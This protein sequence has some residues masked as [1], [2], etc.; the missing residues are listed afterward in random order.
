MKVLFGVALETE[1]GRQ[2]V[3]RYTDNPE[4]RKTKA[5]P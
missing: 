5:M 4:T 3:M 2:R 1:A